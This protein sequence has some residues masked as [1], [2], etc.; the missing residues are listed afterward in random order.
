MNRSFYEDQVYDRGRFQ[1]TDSHT[2]TI[3]T[4]KFFVSL[5]MQDHLN[6]L[7]LNLDTIS[8]TTYIEDIYFY[9]VNTKYIS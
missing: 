1:N 2:H 3:I 4:P 9:E 5:T 7:G 8:Q 6:K